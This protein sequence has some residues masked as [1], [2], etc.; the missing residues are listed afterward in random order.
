VRVAASDPDAPLKAPVPPVMTDGRLIV[1]PNKLNV[2][3]KEATKLSL[4]LSTNVS[5]P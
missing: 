3:E 5:S 1:W 2:K 4:A